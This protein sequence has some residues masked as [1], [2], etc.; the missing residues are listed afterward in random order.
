MTAGPERL[1]FI[2]GF[3]AFVVFVGIK[4]PCPAVGDVQPGAFKCIRDEQDAAFSHFLAYA[5][6]GYM[7]PSQF[8][9]WQ[10]L[11]V[12][13]EVAEL[14][15]DRNQEYLLYIGGGVSEGDQKKNVGNPIDKL[16]NVSPTQTHVWHPSA[17]D[18]VYNFV[19][20]SVGAMMQRLYHK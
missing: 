3:L 1:Y 7:Y 12:L 15:L 16:L 2:L 10:A 9:F 20:F 5:V 14:L 11:G 18:V 4:C 19:G 6:L 8:V 17:S 13:W